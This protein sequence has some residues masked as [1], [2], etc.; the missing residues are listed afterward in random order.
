MIQ[1]TVG[2]TKLNHHRVVRRMEAGGTETKKAEH[3]GSSDKASSA[4][5]GDLTRPFRSPSSWLSFQPGSCTNRLVSIP[6]VIHHLM[7]LET[8]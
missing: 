1:I 7:G 8:Q 4:K 5:A 3:D 6:R 2:E